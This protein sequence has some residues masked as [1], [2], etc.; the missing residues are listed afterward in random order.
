MA[1]PDDVWLTDFGD[2]Y[3][4]EPADRRPAIVCGPTLEWG[5]D[6][7]YVFLV[8]LTTTPRRM[9]RVHVEVEPD[10]VNGLDDTSYAQCE[11]LRSVSNRR[12]VHRLGHVDEMVMG[13]IEVAVRDLLGH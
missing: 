1:S 3:P 12:L 4:G 11:M 10:G 2:P 8:P 7:P 13:Q 6:L 5:T 9:P